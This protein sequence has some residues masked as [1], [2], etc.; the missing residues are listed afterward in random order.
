[1]LKFITDLKRHAVVVGVALGCLSLPVTAKAEIGAYVAI[2]AR[3][4]DVLAQRDAVKKWYP[5]SLT[6]M[7]T[8]YVTFRAIR[9]GKVSLQTPVVQSQNS[10]A[11]PPSKMGFKV[12]TALTLDNALKI[13]L[14]KSANDMA[15]AL[16]E[17]VGGSEPAFIEM[18]NAQARQLGL[19]DTVFVN[20][21]GLPDERQVTTARDMAILAMALRNDFPEA[22][23]Y[24]KY[25]GIKFGKR[26]LR[27]GNREFLL[28]VDGADGLK[29]GYI[30]DAGYNVAASATRGGRT[31]ISVILGAASGLERAAFARELFDKAFDKRSGSGK[32]FQLSGNAGVPPAPGYC[33]RNKDGEM[34]N[35]VAR[36][37]IGTSSNSPV[38]AYAGA[39]SSD[40]GALLIPGQAKAKASESGKVPAIRKADGKVDW[41]KVM[42]LT[43]GPSR[44]EYAPVTVHVGLPSGVVLPNVDSLNIPV[45]TPHPGRSVSKAEVVSPENKNHGALVLND[46][47]K[48]EPTLPTGAAGSLFQKGKGFA[49]PLPSAK[50]TQ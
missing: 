17:A 42:D 40:P 31:I 29:T 33:K 24:Y 49:V 45:P 7:M 12:G 2:D 38:M 4:G 10:I 16:A 37:L 39:V 32:V 11:E 19:K 28:R 25:P 41:L 34:E 14:I 30:C 20:P 1:M 26:S 21:H 18:M 43:I 13:V 22:R 35:F 5:A 36:Y 48:P 3:T 23:D 50:F 47:Y 44:H 9:E 46:F 8:A 27:S 6:K 15:V